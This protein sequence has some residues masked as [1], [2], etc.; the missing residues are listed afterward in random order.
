MAPVKT[1]NGQK[2]LVQIG[3]GADPEVFAVDCLINTERG[4]QFSSD[5]NEF[6]VADCEDPDAPAWKERT[7]DGLSATISGAGMLHTSSI[8]TWFDWFASPDTKNAR[9]KVDVPGASGG[10]Y[11]QGA[12]HLTAFEIT[13]NRNDKATVSVTLESSGV[14]TWVNAT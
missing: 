10:G 7:K 6:V 2:L 3:N 5:S 12:F 14:V 13:G 8:E 4:I 11:W 9:V 1:I